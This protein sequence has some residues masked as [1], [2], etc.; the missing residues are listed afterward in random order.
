MDPLQMQAI[1][2]IEAVSKTSTS[3]V[4]AGPGFS[5]TDIG[6]F[7]SEFDSVKANLSV[8]KTDLTNASQF[9]QKLGESV[10][11]PLKSL[12]ASNNELYKFVETMNAK[13]D[14]KPS[15][16]AKLTFLAS[17]FGLRAELTSNIANRSSDG[18]QQLFRQQS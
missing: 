5:L 8:N 12:N 18:V 14:L 4:Q 7:Q 9:E 15:D 2:A 3:S 13:D 6:R 1:D 16:I 17:D 10:L 11:E